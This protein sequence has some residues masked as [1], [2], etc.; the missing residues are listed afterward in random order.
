MEILAK[1]GDVKR[2]Q[3]AP[4]VVVYWKGKDRTKTRE[5]R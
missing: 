2:Y 4:T 1:E 5:L 3:T